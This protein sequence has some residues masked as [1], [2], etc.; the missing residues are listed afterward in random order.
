M[1]GL[2]ALDLVALHLCPHGGSDADAGE[3]GEQRR[4]V[5][6][7]WVLRNDDLAA[8]SGEADQGAVRE[9]LV[10]EGQERVR[11]GSRSRTW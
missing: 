10:L 7:G 5:R 3:T 4:F 9:G 2:G 8:A 6:H 1:D 11:S